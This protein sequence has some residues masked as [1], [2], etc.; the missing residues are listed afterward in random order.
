MYF[1]RDSLAQLPNQP[2]I[3]KMID[4]SDTI[5][6]IG[7]AKNIKNRVKSYFA[8]T[9]DSIKTRLMVKQI[10]RIEII[11]TT[12][13]KEAFILE[14]HLIKTYK[15]KYNVLLKD[16]KTFPYIKVTMNEPFPR[17]IVTRHK[18]R[19][20]S[21]YYG[22]FPSLG[23]SRSLKKTLYELF[24]IR[25]CKQ[26]I[27]LTKKEPK[28]LLLDINKCIGPCVIKEIKPQYDELIKQLDLLL[29]GRNSTLITHITKQMKALAAEQKFEEAANLRDRLVL[30]ENLTESQRVAL[31]DAHSY[32]LWTF[33]ECDRFYYIMVQELI[34][35]KLISQHGFY[36]EKATCTADIFI[37]KTF[38]SYTNDSVSVLNQVIC[39]DKIANVLTPI[40]KTLKFPDVLIPERGLKKD[41]LANITLNAK[42]ALQRL[43][44]KPQKKPTTTTL[45]AL[46]DTLNLRTI[47]TTIFGFD[48]SHLQ[49]TQIVASAVTFY[50][51]YPNKNAYRKFS[52]KAPLTASHDPESIREAV[53]RRLKLCLDNNEPLPQLLVI[54]GG[55]GQLNFAY[56]S[57]LK[58]GLE[59]QIDIIS[60]AKKHEDI[61]V[62]NQKDPIQIP[63]DDPIIHLLQYIRDESHRF[64]VSFQRNKRN[65]LALQ[66]QLLQI[67]GLGKHRLKALYQAFDSLDTIREASIDE[68]T[69]VSGIGKQLAETIKNTLQ[70]IS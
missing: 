23:S 6:Y 44:L 15:P 50:K 19:D 12:T 26:P 7:K 17:I 66:S 28:C 16:D 13:E 59:S 70:K 58:L 4:N 54:D 46:K 61:Y 62:L 14:N 24:P 49:G 53:Y 57:L 10:A 30:I 60:L 20:G 65:K 52:I 27:S 55:K 51:G 9:I 56:S 31:D 22:P 41:L 25:D 21:R 48:I 47:P 8:K 32:S 33:V 64:A 11:E 38:L 2:G 34:D 42:H 68:L 1:T 63:N 29:T 40:F 69:S 18:Q 37:E 39:S 36:D 3:Y 43:N 35:G 5:I 67:D 45:T